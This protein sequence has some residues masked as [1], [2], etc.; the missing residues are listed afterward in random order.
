MSHLKL[1]I[2]LDYSE[3]VQVSRLIG[4]Y[5]R[6]KT[7]HQRCLECGADLLLA[8]HESDCPVSTV[9]RILDQ[10]DPKPVPTFVDLVRKAWRSYERV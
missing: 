3:A 2:E 8:T 4:A 10:M 7:L 6:M 1:W 9:Q 5:V